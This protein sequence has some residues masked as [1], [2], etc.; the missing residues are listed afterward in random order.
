[1]DRVRLTDLVGFSEEEPARHDVLESDRLWS[2]L[3]CLGRNQSYGPVS[4]E[5]ADCLL[6]IV[7][8]E[9][10][11]QVD[12]GR[13][14][15][16]QWGATLARRGEQLTVTNASADPAVILLVTAPPPAGER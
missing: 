10:V 2:Q 8:G 1:M 13:A 16:Q 7:A 6:V 14:R 12:R 15:L 9:A 4:D 11:V 3:L 5:E